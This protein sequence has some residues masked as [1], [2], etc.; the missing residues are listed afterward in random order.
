MANDFAWWRGVSGTSWICT[1]APLDAGFS[2]KRPAVYLIAR[3]CPELGERAIFVDRT[4]DLSNT[5]RLH[6]RV[7]FLDRVQQVGP[8]RLHVHLAS[9]TEQQQA[10][11]VSDIELAHAPMFN[12][13]VAQR[14]HL[15]T[16]AE[17]RRQSDKA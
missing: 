4:C 6:Q 3:I 1:P 11:V 10:Y 17:R 9:W 7:G 16:Q 5:W 14:H 13:P 12:A 15:R 8:C 2:L